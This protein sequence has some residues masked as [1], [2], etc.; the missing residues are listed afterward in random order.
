MQKITVVPA[1]AGAQSEATL[2]LKLVSSENAQPNGSFWIF[3]I[4]KMERQAKLHFAPGTRLRG[5]DS[6]F[7]QR[8]QL[9]RRPL[10]LFRTVV[11]LRGCDERGILQRLQAV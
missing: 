10:S 6:D 3:R 4:R 8:F 1:Q 7:L 11:R 9:F 5:C 2:Q